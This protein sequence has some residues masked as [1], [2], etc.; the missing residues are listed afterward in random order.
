[1]TPT[2][3]GDLILTWAREAL[4]AADRLDA[5]LHS[6]RGASGTLRMAA[7]QTIAAHLVPEWLVEL[8]R[9]Q[10]VSASTPSQTDLTVANSDEVVALVRR[11]QVAVGFIE[12]PALPSGLASTTIGIER[13]VV[14]V[15]PGH[16]WADRSRV[17]L[18]ELGA[19]PLV[20]REDGSGTRASLELE[21]ARRRITPADPAVVLTTEAAVRSAVIAAVGP[22]VLSPLT[23]ADDTQLGRMR[24]LTIG[25]EPLTRPLTAIWRGDARDLHG[26][27]LELVEVAADS[28]RGHGRDGASEADTAV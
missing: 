4:S 11:G 7:S 16:P 17:A 23:V 6:L 9:R 8:R 14:A 3:E 27:A 10:L 22:A 2:P 20:V 13:M 24:V 1:V 15:H 19:T 12:T 28:L 18:T 5:A 26:H 25:P 21:L